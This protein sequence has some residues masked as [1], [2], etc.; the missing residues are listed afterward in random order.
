MALPYAEIFQDAA[1]LATAGG[2]FFA[3]YQI[4]LAKRQAVTTFEDGLSNEYRAVIH[5]LP[6][7]AVLGG[8]LTD[9][10]HE[11]AF[12]SFYRYFELTNE[13]IF[14]RHEGRISDHTWEQWQN[15][16][17]NLLE[18]PAF[19][20]ARRHF[21]RTIR[22]EAR[23][24]FVKLR[25]FIRE[26]VDCDRAKTRPILPREQLRRRPEEVPKRASAE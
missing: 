5:E 18:L 21:E 4:I 8:E 22:D 10:E 25:T 14:L 11:V 2:L 7:L 1:A 17:A 19:E 24:R 23:P 9:S 6:L 16:I 12:E 13:Q 15:G 3:G 20:S 26:N